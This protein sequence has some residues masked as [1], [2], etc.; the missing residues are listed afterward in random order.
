MKLVKTISLGAAVVLSAVGLAVWAGARATSQ[1]KP[2]PVPSS[3]QSAEN[4]SDAP[5]VHYIEL[6][7]NPER[8]QGR[9]VRTAG[10]VSQLEEDFSGGYYLTFTEGFGGMSSM[11]RCEL[12]SA[13][14]QGLKP[15]DAA[16]VSGVGGAQSL[17][18]YTLAQAVVEETGEDAKARCIALQEEFPTQ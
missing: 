15:G 13:P 11:V 18:V 4:R 6:F 1:G 8:Y 7:E 12:F 14:P 9:M 16:T 2:A 5:S 17:G 3:S 10:V